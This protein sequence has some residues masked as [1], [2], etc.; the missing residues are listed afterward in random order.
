MFCSEEDEASYTINRGV[1]KG[2]HYIFREE[3]ESE[4]LFLKRVEAEVV[5]RSPKS[6]IIIIPHGLCLQLSPDVSDVESQSPADIKYRE[7]RRKL[8]RERIERQA[9]AKYPPKQAQ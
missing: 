9:A 6:E 4:T 1:Y 3:G 2:R 5:E 7:R 8:R